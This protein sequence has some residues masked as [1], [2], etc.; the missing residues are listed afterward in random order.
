MFNVASGVETSLN[1]LAYALLRVM[2][3]DLEPEYGPER[4]VNPVP[5]RLADTSKA[6]RLL[7]FRA[8][9]DLEDGLRRLVEWWRA[10]RQGAS[11]PDR[12]RRAA[13]VGVARM[14]TVESAAVVAVLPRAAAEI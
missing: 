9:I 8:E 11:E 10:E 5:R 6:E 1:D 4:K 7:G 12:R 13:G 14:T 2:G 3:S